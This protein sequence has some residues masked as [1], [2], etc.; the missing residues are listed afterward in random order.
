MKTYKQ[1]HGE[2]LISEIGK[3]LRAIAKREKSDFKIL[4]GYGSSGGT[5]QSKTTSIKSLSK[6]K[7]EGLIKDF[8]PGEVRSQ[9]LLANSA[10]YETKLAYEQQIKGDP[11]YGNDGII[12]VFM[13]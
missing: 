5:S 3:E 9:A 4:T 2:V 10:F 6:M 11:D 7:K 1:F 12:F 13:K 8:L